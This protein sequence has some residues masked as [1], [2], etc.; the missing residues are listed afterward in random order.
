MSDEKSPRNRLDEEYREL[1]AMARQ[2]DAEEKLMVYAPPDF[3][4]VPARKHHIL[5]SRRSGKTE[6]QLDA[7]FAHQLEQARLVLHDVAHA[8]AAWELGQPTAQRQAVSKI[9][10]RLV[11]TNHDMRVAIDRM[12]STLDE[13]DRGPDQP[14]SSCAPGCPCGDADPVGK[15]PC[16]EIKLPEFR[17]RIMPPAAP[18]R[19][20]VMVDLQRELGVPPPILRRARYEKSEPASPAACECGAQKTCSAGPG[21]PMHSAWCPWSQR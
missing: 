10:S 12:S 7:Q 8:L 21:S 5:K 9:M 11:E 19:S 1:L 2:F 17:M 4:P 13:M 16:A 3:T 20:V 18:S 6:A 15:N 14:K